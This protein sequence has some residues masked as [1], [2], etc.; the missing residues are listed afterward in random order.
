M[1]PIFKDIN[2]T[3]PLLGSV[4]HNEQTFTAVTINKLIFRPV[5]ERIVFTTNEF[6][7]V[8]VYEGADYSAHSGDTQSQLIEKLIEIASK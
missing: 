6:D 8:I 5:L 1:E 4:I 3:H 2:E 7:R